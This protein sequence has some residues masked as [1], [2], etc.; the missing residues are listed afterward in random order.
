MR[1]AGL[2]VVHQSPPTA[3]GVHFVTLEDECGLF[4]LIIFPDVYER[5]RRVVRGHSLLLVEGIIQQDEGVTNVLAG[6]VQPLRD[7]G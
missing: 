5:V 1:V 2:I 6:S 3:H 4:D 7:S